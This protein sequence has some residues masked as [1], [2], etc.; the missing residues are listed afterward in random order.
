MNS[1]CFSHDQVT[2]DITAID[3][4]STTAQNAIWIDTDIRL[5]VEITAQGVRMASCT[6]EQI[7]DTC[8]KM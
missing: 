7:Y 4:S 2:Y 6:K 1:V 5:I 3:C 8:N